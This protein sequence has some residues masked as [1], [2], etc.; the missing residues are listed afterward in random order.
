MKWLREKCKKEQKQRKISNLKQKKNS[1]V[2][3]IIKLKFIAR[4][5]KLNT[6]RLCEATDKEDENKNR[7]FLLCVG[8]PTRRKVKHT[9][10]WHFLFS[11]LFLSGSIFSPFCSLVF[12]FVLKLLHFKFSFSLNVAFGSY[13][14]AIQ[15]IYRSNNTCRFFS[16]SDVVY[17]CIS[18]SVLFIL[19]QSK[20]KTEHFIR[21]SM[22]LFRLTF[23][24][25]GAKLF[26]L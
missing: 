11:A 9:H 14:V 19:P 3:R 15:F 23:D 6:H 1:L 21:F 25:F 13:G 26:L 8:K 24:I 7:L 20:A 10:Y 16:L 22:S 5:T 4:W 18:S 17:G 12:F 2:L